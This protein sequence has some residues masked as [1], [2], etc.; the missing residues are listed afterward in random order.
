M[1]SDAICYSSNF[2]IMLTTQTTQFITIFNLAVPGN[3]VIHSRK[4]SSMQYCLTQLLIVICQQFSALSDSTWQRVQPSVSQNTDI[5][6]RE[7]CWKEISKMKNSTEQHWPYF[8]HCG[9]LVR[10][11]DEG[12]P[13]CHCALVCVLYVFDVE[14]GEQKGIPTVVNTRWNSTLRQVNAVLQCYHLKLCAVLDKAG[15]TGSCHSQQGSGIC[16]RSWWTSWSHLEKQLIW[17]GGEGYPKQCCCSIHLA[18]QPPP[19]E[20]ESSNLFPERPGQKSPGI[21]ENG[22]DT[23]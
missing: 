4:L 11:K 1:R 6:I 5:K 18:P 7:P 10:P 13:W 16:W 9:Q 8:S 19:W 12:I 22:Q 20:A 14:F 15:H 17:H 2:N 23:R 21:L 3:W